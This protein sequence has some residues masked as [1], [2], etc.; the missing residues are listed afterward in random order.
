[1]EPFVYSGDEYTPVVL[2]HRHLV[3][4]A[5]T[6][7]CGCT[8]VL[9]AK[10]ADGSGTNNIITKASAG[11]GID[12]VARFVSRVVIES[13]GYSHK[14]DPEV[15]TFHPTISTTVE[16]PPLS[17]ISI[18][19]TSKGMSYVVLAETAHG[20]ISR[21]AIELTNQE[22]RIRVTPT[23]HLGKS[24]KPGHSPYPPYMQASNMPHGFLHWSTV[25]ES[26]LAH[27]GTG[28]KALREIICHA[29]NALYVLE[30]GAWK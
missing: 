27:T 1:V 23:P 22:A 25:E 14:S 4:T 13:T 5:P 11:S 28:F 8:K 21:R 16:V 18:P 10:E 2:M 20:R 7:A 19:G 3:A 26:H 29:V 9:M 24:M 12:Q 6:M 17:T 15:W 30:N